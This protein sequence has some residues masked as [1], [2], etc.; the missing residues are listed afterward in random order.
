MDFSLFEGIA[1]SRSL[2]ADFVYYTYICTSAMLSRLK[3]AFVL[4][5]IE[6]RCTI[7]FN[8]FVSRPVLQSNSEFAD[9]S[10]KQ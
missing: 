7:T 2:V 3:A 5:G 8:E 9:N 4:L 10:E 1:K 6:E